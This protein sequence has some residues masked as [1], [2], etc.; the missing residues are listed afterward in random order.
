MWVTGLGVKLGSTPTCHEVTT[1][2]EVEC[3]IYEIL[4]IARDIHRRWLTE[5]AIYQKQ[6]VKVRFDVFHFGL[7]EV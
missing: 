4:A 3:D 6:G 7:T 1:F 2:S 5:S